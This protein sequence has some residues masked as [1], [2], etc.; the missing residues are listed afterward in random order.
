MRWSWAAKGEGPA[1]GV[2]WLPVVLQQLTDC[3]QAA[4]VSVAILALRRESGVGAV[5]VLALR[6]ESGVGAGRFV[7]CCCSNENSGSCQRTTEALMSYMK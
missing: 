2:P 3:V 6:R 4:S 1:G 5:A 7:Y